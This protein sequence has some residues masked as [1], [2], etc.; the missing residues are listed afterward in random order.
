MNIAFWIIAGPLALFY[1]YAGG[2]KV[3]RSP[4]QLR[5]MMAWVDRL[6]LPAVRAVGV[7][8]ILGALGLILPPL[9]GLAPWLAVAAAIGF[10]FLQLGAI[11][12]HL[13]GEDQRVT[14]NMTLLFVAAV[15][16]WLATTWV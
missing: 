8:E 7:L 14:L 11:P 4:D 2:A 15:T 12:V 9:T 6:P 13:T 1:L 10:V 16:G 3:I 5:P